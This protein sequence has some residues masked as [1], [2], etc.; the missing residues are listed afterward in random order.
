M[1]KIIDEIWGGGVKEAEVPPSARGEAASRPTGA[2]RVGKGI[3]AAIR[4]TNSLFI[5]SSRTDIEHIEKLIVAT[6]QP[7]PQVMI[8]ARIV[9]AG[10]NFARDFGLQWGGAYHYANPYAPLAGSV[11]GF[12]SD[13]NNSAVNIPIG[14]GGGAFTGLSGIGLTIASANLNI[15][16]RLQA[17][18]QLGDIKIVSSPKILTLDN[19]KAMIKQGSKVPVT[20]LD[21]YGAYSTRYED[22][23]LRLEVTPHIARNGK[24]IT[25]NVRIN[26]DRIDDSRDFINGNVAIDTQ[27]ADLELTINS[28]ETLVIGGVKKRS[29]S[30]SERGVPWLKDI[31]VVGWLFKTKEKISEDRELLLFITPKIILPLQEK[32]ESES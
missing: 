8:E 20:T 27:E 26:N 1:K 15:D 3:I 2:V 13:T 24:K 22:A 23:N 14:T 7:T 28:G 18:E 9:E 21:Q 12:T 16:V 31:P 10:S 5:R 19:K 32:F 25:M 30:S 17:F 4:Q 6:D 11:R 29:E